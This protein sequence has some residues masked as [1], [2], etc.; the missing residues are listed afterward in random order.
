MCVGGG[1]KVTS[2]LA[3][4]VAAAAT[5]RNGSNSGSSNMQHAVRYFAG[6][7]SEP[8]VCGYLEGGVAG[9]M[10]GATAVAQQQQQQQHSE[11]PVSPLL[12]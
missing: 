3:A 9:C 7:S 4:V 8:N 11:C 1:G 2:L 5:T 12:G 6:I 10:R